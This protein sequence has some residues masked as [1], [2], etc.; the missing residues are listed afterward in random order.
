MKRIAIRLAVMAITTLS[1]GA[2][3]G[4]LQQDT[5]QHSD[6]DLSQVDDAASARI[7]ATLGDSDVTMVLTDLDG[8]L[9]EPS[10]AEESLMAEAERA[11]D[12]G[13]IPG[14]VT[15]YVGPESRGDRPPS[16]YHNDPELHISIWFSTGTLT[17]FLRWYCP[18]GGTCG[19]HYF[20]YENFYCGGVHDCVEMAGVLI[21]IIPG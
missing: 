15:T 11:L 19:Y 1:I 10:G 4:P 20:T 6:F 2:C 5:P 13:L 12:S 7:T 21:S 3:L 8:N 16:E 17:S 9:V 18:P 14:I